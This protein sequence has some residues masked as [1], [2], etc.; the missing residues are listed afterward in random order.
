[1]AVCPNEMVPLQIDRAIEVR[2]YL[3]LRSTNQSDP[4]AARPIRRRRRDARAARLAASNDRRERG[5]HRNELTCCTGRWTVADPG[6]TRQSGTG[7]TGFCG[8]V[9]IRQR[10]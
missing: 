5:A 1:M 6:D 7:A 3:L 2:R 9:A 8:S 4:A 10:E